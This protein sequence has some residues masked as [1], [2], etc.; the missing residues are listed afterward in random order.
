[1]HALAVADTLCP[2]CR[3]RLFEAALADKSVLKLIVPAEMMWIFKLGPIATFL[4]HGKLRSMLRKYPK[5]YNAEEQQSALTKIREGLQASSSGYL[6][7]DS[8]TF[9]GAPILTRM[10]IDDVI[11][12]S[13]ASNNDHGKSHDVIAAG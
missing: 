5:E 2:V 13:F 1:M 4:L 8:L 9:A 6:L 3:T 11:E 10:P 12:C 7:G